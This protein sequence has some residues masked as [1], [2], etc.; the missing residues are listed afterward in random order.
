MLDRLNPDEQHALLE[1]LIYMAKS[2]GKVQDVENEILHQYADLV[3]VDFESLDGTL[4]P[5]DLVHRFENAVSRTV[6]LQELL[7]LSHLDG[8]FADDEKAA[9]L[10]IAEQ[11][12]L[13]REFVAE[14]DGWVVEGL[15][16]MLRGE[17]LLDKAE[18]LEV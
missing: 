5:Q 4:S 1:L 12:R 8:Y 3:D 2:D 13:P 10:D 18:D 9:I 14:I 6:V 15:R 7:R 16:W 11:M 17:D